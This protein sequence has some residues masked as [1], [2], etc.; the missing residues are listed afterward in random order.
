MALLRHLKTREVDIDYFH[1]YGCSL[2]AGHELNDPKDCS[3]LLGRD[4]HAAQYKNKQESFPAKL[5]ELFDVPFSNRAEYGCSVHA[6]K[7]YFVEDVLRQ[8]IKRNQAVFFCI[9]L[10]FR[11]GTFDSKIGKSISFQYHDAAENFGGPGFLEFNNDYKVLYEYLTTLW[12]VI[13]ITK[14]IGCTLFFVPMFYHSTFQGLKYYAPMDPELP[15]DMIKNEWFMARLLK[16]II[17]EIDCYT[18]EIQ[19][20]MQYVNR[21]E[22]LRGESLKFPGGHPIQKIHDEYAEMMYSELKNHK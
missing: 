9:T 15:Q 3:Q 17:R 7:F 20:L 4:L 18:M 1:F 21:Q 19:P 22:E 11:F 6:T 12:E 13:L 2:P 8:K 16:N 14:T 10:P 5:S